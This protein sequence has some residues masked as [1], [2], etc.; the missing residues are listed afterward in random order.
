[1]Q[2]KNWRRAGACSASIAILLLLIMYAAKWGLAG[3]L[4]FGGVEG[5]RS[6]IHTD[7][8]F[9]AD[10]QT[11]KNYLLR[12]NQLQPHHPDYL[13]QLGRVFQFRQLNEPVQLNT[14]DL[15]MARKYYRESILERPTWPLAW[16]HLALVKSRLNEIDSEFSL[17]IEQATTFGPWEP[18]VQI[19]LSQ[20]SFLHW[21][22]L[23]MADRTQI[24]SNS[25][26]AITSPVRRQFSRMAT[27]LIKYRKLILVCPHLPRQQKYIALCRKATG[28]SARQ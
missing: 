24:I 7:I 5:I 15:V 23:N 25:V 12:A 10:W 14:T 13:Y 28:G 26:R 19:A 17:A 21:Q 18:G 9:P 2:K 8:Q 3:L 6:W 27:L 11:S 20:A 4:A 1:M 16:A 22:Q